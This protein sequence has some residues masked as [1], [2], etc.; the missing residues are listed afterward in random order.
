MFCHRTVQN[1]DKH[2]VRLT[3]EVIDGRSAVHIQPAE[4]ER[5]VERITQIVKY[6]SDLLQNTFF[7]FKKVI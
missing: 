3:E 4:N 2:S 5:I 6:K 7:F 1:D